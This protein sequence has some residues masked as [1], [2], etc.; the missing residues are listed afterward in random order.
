MRPLPPR[1]DSPP[2]AYVKYRKIVQRDPCSYCGGPGGTKDH[3]TP[4]PLNDAPINLAENLTGAC[5][6]CNGLKANLGL[7]NFLWVSSLRREAE[8]ALQSP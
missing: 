8:A 2:V 4:K 5:A 6:D 3:I 1:E 7:L